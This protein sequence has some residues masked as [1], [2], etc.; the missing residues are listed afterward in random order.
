MGALQITRRWTY[1][2]PLVPRGARA[3]RR[4]PL[5]ARYASRAASAALTLGLCSLGTNKKKDRRDVRL[6]FR[7]VT[8]QPASCTVFA[9]MPCLH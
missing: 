7:N 5:C 1:A 9:A 4:A 6:C 3:C 8:A 2:H